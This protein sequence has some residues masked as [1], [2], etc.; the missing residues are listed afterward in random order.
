MH[1]FKMQGKR[2]LKNLMKTQSQHAEW[3]KRV[4]RELYENAKHHQG[5]FLEGS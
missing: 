3:A 5:Q 1:T 2:Y 4:P